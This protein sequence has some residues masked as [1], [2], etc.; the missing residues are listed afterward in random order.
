MLHLPTLCSIHSLGIRAA[1]RILHCV[2]VAEQTEHS[3]LGKHPATGRLAV[4]PGFS[5]FLPLSASIIKKMDNLHAGYWACLPSTN[6][7][8]HN[9]SL[10]NLLLLFQQHTVSAQLW[11]MVESCWE[12]ICQDC[13][14]NKGIQQAFVWLYL[15]LYSYVPI[16]CSINTWD[17]TIY[18]VMSWI[19]RNTCDP[20]HF[21]IKMQQE[22]RLFAQGDVITPTHTALR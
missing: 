1:H 18:T 12:H 16:E 5:L 15:Y 14:V 7:I 17:R 3:H 20:R 19:L 9:D 8:S 10:I 2:T 11:N 22:S 6:P 21:S 4:M 13:S